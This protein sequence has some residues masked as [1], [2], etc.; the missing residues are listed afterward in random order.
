MLGTDYRG[1]GGCICVRFDI[2]IMGYYGG[3]VGV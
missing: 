3:W 2:M 1:V